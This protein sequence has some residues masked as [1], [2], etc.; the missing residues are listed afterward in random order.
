MT[1]LGVNIDHVATLRQARRTRYPDPV[2]AAVVAENSGADQITV[3]LREDRRHIQEYDLLTLRKTV[4]TMLNLELAASREIVD[5]AITARP[6]VCTFVPEKRQELTTEG[7]LDVIKHFDL[8]K[9]YIKELKANSITVSLFIDPENEQVEASREIGADAIELHTGQFCELFDRGEKNAS[10]EVERLKKSAYHANESGLYVA[11][12]H[13]LNYDNVGLV[14]K[15]VPEIVEY[16]IGHS[17]I[18]RSVFVGLENAVRQMKD[19]LKKR[20]QS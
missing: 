3:H 19:L 10:K 18:A 14:L 7:G 16:N 17:I 5:I 13:G 20:S 12:G 1:K 9:T 6:D 2:T 15:E 8:L 4:R 11:A